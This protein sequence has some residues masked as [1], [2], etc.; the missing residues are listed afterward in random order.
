[1][2]KRLSF[3]LML[4]LLF[5]L[6]GASQSFAGGKVKFTPNEKVAF[7][8]TSERQ[9][10][11]TVENQ[12]GETITINTEVIDL[13]EKKV[14]ENQTETLEAGKST[15]IKL[16]VY[17]LLP[18]RGNINVYKVNIKT[19]NG[20]KASYS[21]AQK[22]LK[23]VNGDQVYFQEWN[24]YRSKNTASS[25]GLLFRDVAP[26]STKL[27]YHF[28]PVDLSIQGRQTFP[29]LASNMYEIGE[30]YVDVNEDSCVVSYHIYYSDSG[31]STKVT[32]EY[33]NIFHSLKD[34]KIPND[35]PGQEFIDPETKF[36]FNVPFS[37]KYD[38][39]GDTKVLLSIRNVV[40]YEL[41]PR[42]YNASY[43]RHWPNLKENKALREPLRKLFEEIKL[44]K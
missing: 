19:S 16:G 39:D 20:A 27:W 4:M 34:A 43:R 23:D 31:G 29:L 36:A 5:S 33:M 7:N 18:K 38:L 30:V 44:K 24:R 41:F 1:M 42:S 40:D 10:A 22:Y 14:V 2:K 6:I 21:F 3:I 9:P 17:K 37:I 12:T 35:T 32:K 13:R 26:N 25:F 8:N 11:V 15:N 28:T